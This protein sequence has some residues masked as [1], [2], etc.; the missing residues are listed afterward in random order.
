MWEEWRNGKAQESGEIHQN[1]AAWALCSH[2]KDRDACDI[3]S[4]LVE[5]PDCGKL[6]GR[7]NASD[8]DFDASCG[9]STMRNMPFAARQDQISGFSEPRSNC[10]THPPFFFF[11]SDGFLVAAGRSGLAGGR[12]SIGGPSAAAPLGPPSASFFFAGSIASGPLGRDDLPTGIAPLASGFF[13]K[14]DAPGTCVVIGPAAARLVPGPFGRFMDAV[15][16]LASGAPAC[17]AVSVLTR[18]AID[19]FWTVVAI[20]RCCSRAD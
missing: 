12:V 11:S 10:P 9:T 17:G 5:F 8:C 13:G 15:R 1:V 2:D 3:Q 6:A 7:R 4:A 16:G 19:A 20:S 14:G 18:S